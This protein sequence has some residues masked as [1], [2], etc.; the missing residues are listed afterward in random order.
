MLEREVLGPPDVAGVL[1]MDFGIH[2]SVFG[3]HLSPSRCLT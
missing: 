2:A 1:L 3:G